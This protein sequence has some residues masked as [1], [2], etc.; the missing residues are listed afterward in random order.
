[1]LSKQIEAFQSVLITKPIG[2]L[3]PLEIQANTTLAHSP[4]GK[5]ATPHADETIL[6]LSYRPL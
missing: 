4:R 1:M 5:A 6:R 3:L 2:A